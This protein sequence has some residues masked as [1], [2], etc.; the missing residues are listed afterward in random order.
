MTTA[1]ALLAEFPKPAERV[2]KYG[3]AGFREKAVLLDSVFLRVR[4]L[5]CYFVLSVVE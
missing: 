2:F 1:L 3:T 5:F 4:F